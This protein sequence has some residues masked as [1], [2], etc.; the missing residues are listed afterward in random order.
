V[1]VYKSQ[2]A[3]E[4]NFANT[5]ATY[6]V[7]RVPQTQSQI[8][9]NPESKGENRLHCKNPD[10]QGGHEKCQPKTSVAAAIDSSPN[11]SILSI[12]NPASVQ[13]DQLSSVSATSSQHLPAS[14]NHA[15]TSDLPETQKREEDRM[16]VDDDEAPLSISSSSVVLD[17]SQTTWGRH[18]RTG[19][20]PT[21]GS[22]IQASI[23]PQGRKRNES[24]ST[25]LGSAR[26]KRKSDTHPMLQGER[27]ADDDEEN[28][29]NGSTQLTGSRTTN[30]PGSTSG[31][32]LLG[33][34]GSRR[35]LRSQLAS[36]ARPGSQLSA[37]S[38]STD[39]TMQGVGQNDSEE[40][41][42]LDQGD[43]DSD[44]QEKT[45][46]DVD[47]AVD[48]PRQSLAPKSATSQSKP[49]PVSD[50]NASIDDE[51]RDDPMSLLSQA[52]TNSSG[53]PSMISQ[54]DQIVHPEI[55]KTDKFDGDLTL[56]L[57][58]DKLKL[59]WSQRP[60]EDTVLDGKEAFP[61][62]AGVSN[63]VEDEK[64]V[65][66]LSRVIKKKDFDEMVV[67]GQF[68]LGFIVVRRHSGGADEMDDLFIVD[69]HAADEKYNF[70]TL[71]ATTKIQSQ[72]LFRC[73]HWDFD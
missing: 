62:D 13:N 34:L 53:R 18:L 43:Q 45:G 3:L 59:V 52:L 10:D 50:G 8:T 65:V 47:Y 40:V 57:D 48:N 70:E 4:S 21:S 36:F 68:N 46:E 55:I 69:Q 28:Q 39:D 24:I 72:K 11:T 35:T 14:E 32:S 25:E 63:M 30:I 23:A 7:S 66:A 20:Q 64:A 2:A 73:V 54:K 38:L 19:T 29:S 16:V 49:P 26:K 56:R 37:A 51:D 44:R 6:D 60:S 42:E 61:S 27:H 17:T 58:I 71:Q 15:A 1:I 22:Q 67:V 9:V 41:D 5:R 31:H 33:G 12:G